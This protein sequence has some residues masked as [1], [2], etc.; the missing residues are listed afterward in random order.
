M[1]TPAIVVAGVS[2]GVGKT[3]VALGLMQALRD[4]GLKVQP[5]KVG[6]DFLDPMQ[7]QAACSVPSVNL[8]GWMLGRSACLQ[9]YAAACEASGA[10]IAIVEGVMGLHDGLDGMSDVGS[11]AEIAKWLGVPVVLVLDAWCLSRSAAAMVLGYSSFDPDVLVEGVIFN[12]VNT[13]SHTDWLRQGM[14]SHRDT[15]SICVLGSLPRDVRIHIPERHLGLHRPQHDASDA[16]SHDRLSILSST[17]Q[18]AINLTALLSIARTH[19]PA[20]AAHRRAIA[21]PCPVFSLRDEGLP[22]VRIGVAQDSAFCF[23]YADNLRLLEA[24]GAQLVPFSPITDSCLP[25]VDGLIFGGGYPELYAQALSENTA[26]RTAVRDFAKQGNFVWA[27]CGGLMYLARSLRTLPDENSDSARPCTWAMCGVLPISVAMTPALTMGYCTA[28]LTRASADILRL[29]LSSSIASQ[30][31]HKSE[32]V[33]ADGEPALQL[34]THGNSCGWLGVDTPAFSVR[35]ERPAAVP[36]SEG[37][38]ISRT[39]A[40]YCHVH[41][42]SHPQLAPSI[43][44]AARSSAC[45]VS[46]LPSATEIVAAILGGDEGLVAQR[47]VGVSAHCDYPAEVTAGIRTCTKS[48]VDFESMNQKD[49]EERLRDLQAKGVRDLY[50]LDTDWLREARPAAVL[51]QDACQTCDAAESAVVRALAAAGLP[52]ECAI[53]LNPKSVDDILN[54]VSKIGRVLGEESRSLALVAHLQSRLRRVE[55]A[56]G[57]CL[58]AVGSGSQVGSGFMGGFQGGCQQ[59][60]RVLGLESVYPLVASGQWLPDMR[61]RAG[62]IDALG[63]GIGDAP[64]RVQWEE[65]LASAPDVIVLVCCGKSAREAA[66]EVAVHFLCRPEAWQLPALL[67]VPPRLFVADHGPF[68]R[69]GPRVVTGIELLFSIIYPPSLYPSLPPPPPLSQEAHAVVMQLMAPQGADDVSSVEGWEH[70]TP[71]KALARFAVVAGDGVADGGEGGAAKVRATAGEQRGRAMTYAGGGEIAIKDAADRGVCAGAGELAWMQTLV[72]GASPRCALVMVGHSG[73]RLLI[74]GGDI[75]EPGRRGGV[76]EHSGGTEARLITASSSLAASS[77]AASAVA[78]P[79]K[80]EDGHVTGP[81]SHTHAEVWEL[82]VSAC[83]ERDGGVKPGGERPSVGTTGTTQR[84]R[85][86]TRTCGGWLKMERRGVAGEDEVPI[87]RKNHAGVLWGHILMVFGG[88]TNA[89]EVLGDLEMLDLHT[90]CWTHGSSLGAPPTSRGNPSAIIWEGQGS[91]EGGDGG[92]YLVIYGGW[93]GAKRYSD[94]DV[95]STV[96]WTWRRV[97]C[98]PP[99]QG[100]DDLGTGKAQGEGADLCPD[101]S[102]SMAGPGARTDHTAC[103]WAGGG[104]EESGRGRGCMVVFGGSTAQGLHNDVWVLERVDGDGGSGAVGGMGDGWSWRELNCSGELPVARSSHGAIMAGDDMIVVGGQ[105]QDQGC[106]TLRSVFALHMPT[107]T[108]RQLAPLPV[109]LCRI[110]LAV[111]PRSQSSSEDGLQV[112]VW[113]GWDGDEAQSVLWSLSLPTNTHAQ[114]A[115]GAASPRSTPAAAAHIDFPHGEPANPSS[116]D[117]ATTPS[118]GQ[119][120]VSWEAEAPGRAPTQE[121]RSW[122]VSRPLKLEALRAEPEMAAKLADIEDIGRGPG[123]VVRLL[124]A[125][126]VQRGYGQYID[127]ATGFSVFTSLFLKKRACCG[128]GCRHCPWGHVNVP[129]KQRVSSSEDGSDGDE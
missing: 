94:V 104:A 35:M 96:D 8:D 50:E 83:L 21:Q 6:P 18:S 129:G 77:A 37:V 103:F 73:S 57:Q 22:R 58:Q 65:L 7:H 79:S 43:V 85:R 112:F 62:A 19:A 89:H 82:D 97:S 88:W 123:A 114:R 124:H 110:G 84:R 90:M 47:L 93:D 49:V 66:H 126:A 55:R 75:Q 11:S 33:G 13:Q 91:E 32:V 87:P 127:P 109:S 41:L 46:L 121:L 10:D 44:G 78:R 60:P 72:A 80:A 12:R 68:S 92:D 120:A 95:L 31:F 59:R 4:T 16:D 101:M 17:I 125:T 113:G 105:S 51:T 52:R 38:C 54:D 122:N 23:Y 74:V 26:M 71:E 36:G 117:A 81:P 56:V 34:D 69:P 3:T 100:R 25:R 64:R 99:A 102:R 119:G 29:P 30:V 28:S 76:A 116:G 63:G 70:L 61:Q 106:V 67:A 115:R 15:A 39:I 2:S 24:A 128:N 14:L 5:F 40:S 108:W 48:L 1:D 86:V 107:E 42:A 111:L 45:V 27:E 118:P 9:S 53:T 98:L 20:A